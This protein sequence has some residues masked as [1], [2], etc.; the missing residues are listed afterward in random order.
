MDAIA[1]RSAINSENY[2]N[3]GLLLK[4]NYHLWMQQYLE[5]IRTLNG[6]EALGDISYA[7]SGEFFQYMP[8]VRELAAGWRE[9]GHYTRCKFIKIIYFNQFSQLISLPLFRKFYFRYY[10]KAVQIL[11]PFLAALLALS[12]CLGERA[13]H[14]A[15]AYVTLNIQ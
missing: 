3:Y 10:P 7:T 15:C 6:L 4:W 14:Q 11:Q 5:N 12:Q 2:D 8:G 13:C 9:T 1:Q